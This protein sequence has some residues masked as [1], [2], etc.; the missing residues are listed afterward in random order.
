MLLLRVPVKEGAEEACNPGES[1]E[2]LIREEC[3]LIFDRKIQLIGE[4]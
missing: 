3:F 4:A 2:Q 1:T